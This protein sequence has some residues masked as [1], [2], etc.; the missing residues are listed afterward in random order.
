MA[1]A[2][3]RHLSRRAPRRG[4]FRG[5]LLISFM[6]PVL[7]LGVGAVVLL[8]LVASDAGESG[9]MPIALA[10]GILAGFI[11]LALLT[12]AALGL[13]SGDR[14]TRPVAW[15][16]RAIDAG[17]VRMLSQL[18]PPTADWEMDMLC[19][20]VRV[21]LRQNLSGA[22]ALE[23]LEALRSEVGAVLTAARNGSVDLDQWPE[24][25]ATHEL[26]L[27]LLAHF[28]AERSRA[29]TSADGVSRLQ[30][31]L[32]QDWRDETQAMEELVKRAERAFLQ[33]TQLA[34]ETERVE[35]LLHASRRAGGPWEEIATLLNDLSLGI[36]K[37]RHEVEQHLEEAGYRG[38]QESEADA[39]RSLS[40]R[41]EDW[42]AWV[43]ESVA[44]LEETVNKERAR[45]EGGLQ[46][47]TTGMDRV[48]EV[49]AES[50]HEVSALSQEVVAHQRAWARLGERLRSLM[51]RV[52]E[53][54]NGSLPA[55]IPEQEESD[56]DAG[57]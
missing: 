9:G 18:P 48:T 27:R 10:R 39:A 35:R 46:R 5:R 45:Y 37:W 33:Q 20:R 17:Q 14:L 51:V 13:Q 26:T 22:K 41:L 55:V 2:L 50:G 11:L 7:L 47:V 38:P 31:V 32:E 16:L 12:A 44:I 24:E 23:E 3:P 52:A 34:V 30:G 42:D 40:Q 15:L 6:I 21:L 53:A 56:S 29:H 4:G 1:T 57:R 36:G 28:R 49:V 54:H 43:R 19:N 8:E 25:Q